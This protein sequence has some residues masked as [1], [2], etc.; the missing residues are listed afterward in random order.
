MK[1]TF[2]VINYNRLFYLKSCVE[3]LIQSIDDYDG[4]VEF[5]C[6]D[7]NSKEEGTQEYLQTLK[8]RGW[9]VI[10]QQDHRTNTKADI[11]AIKDLIDEFSAALN[12]LQEESSGDLIVPLQ[13]DMQF[14]RKNWL[15][16]YVSLFTERD[17]A[18]V[19][20]LDAQRKVRLDRTYFTNYAKHGN[21]IFAVNPSRIV[22]GAG[23]CFYRRECLDAMDWWQVGENNNA[24]DLFTIAATKMFPDKKIYMPW[25]PASIAIYTD[26]RGTMGR[27]RGNTRYG[28]YW[29]ALEGDMYYEWV[30]IKDLTVNTQRPLCIEE[31]A[32]A[33]GEWDL[34]IDEQGNW[35]KNPI[36]WP[37]E[38]E[39]V[40]Y[41]TIY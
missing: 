36:N 18:F 8:D 6:I 10:N 22:P 13:G 12:I 1:V 35:K 17:D 31:M 2:A 25:I 27:V 28:L 21:N 38:T 19:A 5:I 7:D 29:E 39:N 41:K 9:K 11:I 24:E 14:V 40:P 33:K 20:M 34:P 23:D 37:V 15:Q 4:E 26:P 16:D 30:D 32:C 3:S